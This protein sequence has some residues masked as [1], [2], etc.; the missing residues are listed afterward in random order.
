ME[1]KVCWVE[2]VDVA[3]KTYPEQRHKKDKII[4]CLLEDICAEKFLSYRQLSDPL[5]AQ[6]TIDLKQQRSNGEY[7][8]LIS[9]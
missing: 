5:I 3:D 2:K 6:K 4:R 9:K 7:A 8:H 1:G